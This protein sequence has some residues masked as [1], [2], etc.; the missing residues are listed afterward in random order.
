MIH[1]IL[2]NAH[3]FFTGPYAVPYLIMVVLAARGFLSM[4]R[5]D[6]VFSRRSRH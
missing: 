6:N 2:T 1:T 3:D 5:G 4:I